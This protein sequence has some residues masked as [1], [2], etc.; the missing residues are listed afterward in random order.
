MDVEPSDINTFLDKEGVK[1][2]NPNTD[3]IYKYDDESQQV[4]NTAKPWK[5]E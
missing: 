3:N 1:S 5:D 4:I 2:V